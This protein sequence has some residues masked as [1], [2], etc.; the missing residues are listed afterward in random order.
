MLIRCLE[1]FD[2][3]VEF[4]FI[5][6]SDI[7]SWRMIRSAVSSESWMVQGLSISNEMWIDILRLC[8]MNEEQA[9]QEFIEY[10]D[11]V[12]Q[13][14]IYREPIENGEERTRKEL[15]KEQLNEERLKWAEKMMDFIK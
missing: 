15:L 14:D 9:K 13:F 4:G 8:D 11:N 10:I 1:N 12:Q 3:D 6:I 5:D 2:G 7:T